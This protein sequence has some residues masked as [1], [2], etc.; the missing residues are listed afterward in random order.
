MQ[1]CRGLAWPGARG[2]LGQTPP[3]LVNLTEQEGLGQVPEAGP[4]LGFTSAVLEQ[5]PSLFVFQ[6]G[7]KA[8]RWERSRP[9]FEVAGCS[10]SVSKSSLAIRVS[11]CWTQKGRAGGLVPRK[12]LC[13]GQAVAYEGEFSDILTRFFLLTW[14]GRVIFAVEPLSTTEVRK[15]NR[16]AIQPSPTVSHH[17][18]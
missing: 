7:C 13:Q 5:N 14:K 17:Y 6:V 10:S 8:A 4:S 18:F 11:K 12:Y 16:A 9:L 2:G 15:L 3:A 1:L